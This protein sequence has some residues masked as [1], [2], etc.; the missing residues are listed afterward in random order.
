MDNNS[1]C[2]H[3][4]KRN[5]QML[6]LLDRRFVAVARGPADDNHSG[7]TS[8]GSSTVRWLPKRGAPS[9]ADVTQAKLRCD[10]KD[11]F[12]LAGD[13]EAIE[14]AGLAGLVALDKHAQGEASRCSALFAPALSGL[15]CVL[16]IEH[17]ANQLLCYPFL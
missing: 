6:T 5:V 4:V 3:W 2:K 13:G 1:G 9:V 11:A 12:A 16:G 14:L 10:T 15:S 17:D 8:I 7:S